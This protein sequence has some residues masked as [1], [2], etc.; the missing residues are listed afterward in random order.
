MA[1]SVLDRIPALRARAQSFTKAPPVALDGASKLTYVPLTPDETLGFD[2]DFR[3]LAYLQDLDRD[4]SAL[5]LDD[6]EFYLYCAGIAKGSIGTNPYFAGTAPMGNQIG[7]QMIRAVTVRNPGIASPSLPTLT[8][9]QVW[10]SAGWQDVFGSA[11]TP[12]DLS[13]T[14]LGTGATNMQN[15]VM[16]AVT[17]LINLNSP[18]LLQEYRWHI[19]NV[20]YAVETIAWEQISSLAYA[21]LAN[22]V[23]IP[24]NG[25]FFFRGNIQPSGTDGTALFGLT[26]AT[27]TYLTYEV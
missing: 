27:A 3:R 20:D 2:R 26:F 22:P 7:M 5:L 17:G 14:G 15:R 4:L 13:Q 10:G 25:R 9:P 24:V 6:E 8:W 23:I 16:L 19:Q 21:R 11:A 18:P 1:T 12:V